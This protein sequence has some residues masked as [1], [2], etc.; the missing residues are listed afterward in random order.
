M[1]KL[2]A[3]LLFT[4]CIAGI[5]TSA[6]AAG[7]NN[8]PTN[9]LRSFNFSTSFPDFQEVTRL[10]DMQSKIQRGYKIAKIE[11]EVFSNGWNPPHFV[12]TNS[13]VIN[14]IWTAIRKIRIKGNGA[15]FVTDSYCEIR[16]TFSDGM[17]YEIFFTRRQANINNNIYSLNNDSEFWAII[18][19]Y[20]K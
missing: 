5:I 9:R 18:D 13:Q 7:H 3:I 15:L 14:Q 16:F 8:I 19:R 1:K 12:T 4:I 10:N 20:A 6:S 2:I 17:E 11:Y